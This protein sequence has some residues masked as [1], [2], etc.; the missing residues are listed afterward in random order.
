MAGRRRAMADLGQLRRYARTIREEASTLE[1]ALSDENL[2]DALDALIHIIGLRG[3]AGMVKRLGG[4]DYHTA[5]KVL[6]QAEKILIDAANKEAKWPPADYMGESEASMG[7]PRTAFEEALANQD[8]E[9]QE[10][11]F[12]LT[13]EEVAD[14]C[15]SC[16]EKMATLKIAKVKASALYSQDET[17]EAAD[18]WRTMPEGWTDESRKKFWKSIGGSVKKCMT[19]MEGKVSDTGAFCASLKDRIEG[20][21]T[22]R[23]P[24]KKASDPV[25]AF[26]NA[27]AKL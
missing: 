10:Q 24:E 9:P 2:V 22:W 7:N 26:E 14:I 25:A 15:P 27:K 12:W 16:A 21:T 18:A 23:G 17:K 8:H 1:K 5:N 4:G 19:K 11:D 3:A 6:M 20:K 13:A